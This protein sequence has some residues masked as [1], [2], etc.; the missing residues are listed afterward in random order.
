MCCWFVLCQNCLYCFEVG[1]WCVLFC[2]VVI[3]HHMYTCALWLANAF[4]Y[5]LFSI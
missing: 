1:N 4:D 3:W 2:F 5:P